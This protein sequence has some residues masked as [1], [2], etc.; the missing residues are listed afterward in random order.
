MEQ[1]Q[2][3]IPLLPPLDVALS[4]EEMLDMQAKVW[5]ARKGGLTGYQC[6]ICHNKGYIVRHE[7]G[8]MIS[9]ECNCM[10]IRSTIRGIRESGLEE[11]LRKCKFQNFE[12]TEPWQQAMKSAAMDFLTESAIGF[13]IGGQSGS[14]KTHICTAIVGGMIKKGMSAR[15][16]V[17]REDSP[18]LKSIVNDV[19]YA[20]RMR[21]FKQTDCL[22]IDDLFKQVT[23]TDA[24][25]KLAFELI[26]YRYRNKMVTIISTE[27]TEDALLGVDEALG[28]R[29]LQMSRGHRMVIA[30]DPKRNYRLR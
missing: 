13:F 6:D 8:E 1:M 2:S 9:S 11:Q 23:I 20:L 12:T 15:Y 4:S 10:K 18:I 17:W 28:G 19:E 26:D 25:I 24:D 16:F 21:E 7:N 30:K 29:I 3:L 5:N 22:Y 27:L 14:G